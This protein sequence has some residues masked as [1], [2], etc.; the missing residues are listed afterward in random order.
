MDLWCAGKLPQRGAMLLLSTFPSR[1]IKA[2]YL[3]V[4]HCVLLYYEHNLRNCWM[5]TQALL[6]CSGGSMRQCESDGLLCGSMHQLRI[7]WPRRACY[8]E[9]AANAGSSRFLFHALKWISGELANYLNWERCLYFFYL[10]QPTIKAAY[11]S[12]RHC[13]LLHYK[14]NLR[15]CWM[16]TQGPLALLQWID[17]SV[18]YPMVCFGELAANA[19]SSRFLPRSEMDL[20]C[21]GKLPQLGAM[22]LLSTFPRTPLKRHI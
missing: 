2:A 19:R 6:P 3:S 1:A 13:V 21:A 8:G 20:W 17:A 9:L 15:N 14:H 4:R 11:L 22:L 7:R 12:A 16:Y 18:A 10:P 5:Y